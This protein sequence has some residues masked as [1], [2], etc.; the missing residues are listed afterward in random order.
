MET[1]TQPRLILPDWHW[2]FGPPGNDELSSLI[3]DGIAFPWTKLVCNLGWGD[4]W[5]HC[6]CL[7][8]RYSHGKG[9]LYTDLFCAPI[10]LFFGPQSL[11]I[12]KPYKPWVLIICGAASLQEYTPTRSDRVGALKA[13][14][15]KSCEILEACLFCC[16]YPPTGD[17]ADPHHLT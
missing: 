15:L 12:L 6:S 5:I 7:M 9:R 16:S 10:T 8:S 4:S 17:L 2:V 11:T 14:S 3:R 13:P 1:S